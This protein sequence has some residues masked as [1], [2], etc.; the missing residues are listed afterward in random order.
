MS[1]AT[2]PV[3][4]ALGNSKGVMSQDLEVS[5]HCHYNSR[6]VAGGDIFL[7]MRNSPR[8]AVPGNRARYF[9]IVFAILSAKSGPEIENVVIPEKRQSGRGDK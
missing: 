4:D 6:T 2:P 9:I 5:L 3:S 8:F 7:R 1:L